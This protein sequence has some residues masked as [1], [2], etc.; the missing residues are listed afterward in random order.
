MG[1]H[2]IFALSFADMVRIG[3]SF[4]ILLEDEDGEGRAD[5]EEVLYHSVLARSRHGRFASSF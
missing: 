3:R 2:K 4:G 1:K 5:W